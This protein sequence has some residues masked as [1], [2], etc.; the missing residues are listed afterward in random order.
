MTIEVAAIIAAAKA[1][2]SEESKTFPRSGSLGESSRMWK[3]A[4]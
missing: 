2:Q 4:S 1:C 3:A